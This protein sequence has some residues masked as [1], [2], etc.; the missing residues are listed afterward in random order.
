MLFLFGV[1]IILH[2][3][4]IR[5]FLGAILSSFQGTGTALRHNRRITLLNAALT[6][7]CLQG[8]FLPDDF[9]GNLG[10]H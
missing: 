6:K 1:T 7:S 3:V 8:L 10:S 2:K 5:I 4:L 9:L